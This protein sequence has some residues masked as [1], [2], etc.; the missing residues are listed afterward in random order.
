M[1]GINGFNFLDQDQ[2][3]CMN[4]A[5]HHRGPDD[6]GIFFDEDVTFGHVRLSIVDLSAAGHQPMV[7]EHSGSRAVIVFNGEIY[8]FHDLRAELINKGYSFKSGTDTEVILASYFEFGFD[9]V[10]HFNGM[11]AFVIYDPSNK[12]FFCSR[13]RLGVKPLYYFAD[14]DRFI[15]SSELKGILTHEYLSLNSK[16]NIDIDAL[17]LYFAL[18]FIP[19]PFTIYTNVYKLEPRQNLVYDLEKKTMKKW[20]YY[21][22]PNYSPIYDSEKL[23]AEGRALLEDAV[24]LRMVADVPVGAFLSGG[25]D[26]TSVVGT[27]RQFKSINDLHTFSIGFEGKYDESHFINIAK[28]FFNTVHHHDYFNESDFEGLIGAYS[29][30]YDEPFGDYSGFP[31]LKLSRMAKESVTVSLSGD[32][33]DEVFG[34]YESHVL[35]YRMTILR[36]I[37]KAF[38]VLFSKVPATDNYGLGLINLFKKACQASLYKPSKFYSS[39]LP[40]FEAPFPGS[41]KGWTE[42]RLKDCLE[43]GCD[44][45]ADVL[46]LYDLMYGMLPDYFLVKVDRASMAYALEVRSPFLD[47][48]FVEFSQHIPAEW[49]VDFFKSKKLMRSIVKDLVPAEILHRSKKGFTPPLNDWILSEKYSLVLD[50]ACD[51]LKDLNQELYDYYMAKVLGRDSKLSTAFKIKLFIFGK[52]YEKWIVKKV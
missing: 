41:C 18:G 34:G 24:R 20:Y 8:N 12:L 52:W 44:N 46:R 47:Y 10:K 45:F 31:T 22:V 13:D 25:I 9:C 43:L 2:A 51:Y 50:Q 17:N 21:K 4:T 27:I 28:D 5:I 14:A 35:G 32:G 6:E 49:K 37:P 16:E 3:R 39:A 48:R 42:E 33:G 26:S 15:F 29:T 40:A 36:K 7:Y 23:I 1:C 30:V 38:R 19:S 11:W